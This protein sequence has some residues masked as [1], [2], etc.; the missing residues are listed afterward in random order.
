MVSSA[1]WRAMVLL[2]LVSAFVPH[3]DP[4]LLCTPKISGFGT[5]SSSAV[6]LSSKQAEN[7]SSHNGSGMN[8]DDQTNSTEKYTVARAGG[9]RLRT[10]AKSKRRDA[11]RFF[12]LIRDLALPLC[13]LSVVLRFLFGMFGGSAGNPGVVYYSHSVYQSTS[14]SKD[15]KIERTMR[16]S[17]QSN[18]PELVEHAKEYTREDF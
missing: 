13:L 7:H 6:L 11:N 10:D 9:R 18:I 17:F 12:P 5:G 2:P 14:Y 1:T 8:F 4:S 15:G 3:I 16:E